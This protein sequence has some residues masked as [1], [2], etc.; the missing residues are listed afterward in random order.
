MGLVAVG[1]LGTG[2]LAGPIS[3]PAYF[4]GRQPVGPRFHAQVTGRKIKRTITGATRTVVVV[5][6][7]T[8]LTSARVV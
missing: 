4:P 1:L 3:R 2:R 5:I 6:D 7:L 8:S